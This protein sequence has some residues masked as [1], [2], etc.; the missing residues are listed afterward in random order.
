MEE[1]KGHIYKRK[2]QYSQKETS[3]APFRI[4]VFLSPV[5]ANPDYLSLYQE[6]CHNWIYAISPLIVNWILQLSNM[7]AFG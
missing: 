1:I 6:L 2:K 4:M 3:D 5:T 7:I